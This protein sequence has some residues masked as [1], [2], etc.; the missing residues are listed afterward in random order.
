MSSKS[1]HRKRSKNLSIKLGE[2]RISNL[3]SCLIVKIISLL[4]T[5]DAVATNTLS[6][7]W[8][9]LWTFVTSLDF[10]DQSISYE[11]S[12]ESFKRFVNQVLL[13]HDKSCLQKFRLNCEKTYDGSLVQDW[14]SS[15]LPSKIQE[16]DLSISKERPDLFPADIFRSKMLVVLKLDANKEV[17]I[18][19]S[20]L[21]PNL[22]TLHLRNIE[23]SYDLSIDKLLSGCPVLGELLLRCCL[24]QAV[25]TVTII[26]PTLTSLTIEWL[27]KRYDVKY[28]LVLNTPSL[29]HFSLTDYVAEGCD[30]KN[31]H[32]LIVAKIAITIKKD[33]EDE[34]QKKML[35]NTLT[36]LLL[37]ISQVQR[38]CLSYKTMDA[39]SR[40]LPVLPEFS[41]LT[42]MESSMPYLIGW[43]SQ[44]A[45]VEHSPRLETLYVRQ[46]GDV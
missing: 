29:Q 30:M 3:P 21:L 28:R 8:K 36:N 4:P 25:S 10:S 44:V 34:V 45:L 16:L 32:N 43:K 17:N 40:C 15:L 42:N 11:Q 37:A 14:I 9:L 22:K 39:I 26:S 19:T 7:K 5:K 27:Q 18:P 33:F 20:I 2:D 6:T 41:N 35:A 46:V 23:L 24:G 1:K 31:M 13:L 12:T 38:L